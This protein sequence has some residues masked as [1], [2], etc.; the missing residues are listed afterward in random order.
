MKPK[1]IAKAIRDIG[2]A[3]N[4]THNTV[5][6]DLPTAKPGKHSWRV[7]HRKELKQLAVLKKL[8]LSRDIAP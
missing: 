4:V 2:L 3:L 5:A 6:T 1:Q 8:L 7:N